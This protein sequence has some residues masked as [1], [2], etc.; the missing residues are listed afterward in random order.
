M[1]FN[2]RVGA[3]TAGK[4]TQRVCIEIWNQMKDEC[5]PVLN[6]EEWLNIAEGFKKNANFPHCIG[7]IDGKHIRLIRPNETGTMHF[8]YKKFFSIVLLAAVDANYRFIFVNI[9]SYG[10]CSDS[11]IFQ[12]CNLWQKVQDKSIDLPAPELLEG[13]TSNKLPYV[14]VADEAFAL[15]PNLLRPYGGDD[16]SSEKRI[17]NYRLTRARRYVECAFGILAN[18]WRIFHRPMNVHLDFA[19]DIVKACCV[20]H[21]HVRRREGIQSESMGNVRNQFE[22]ITQNSEE[23]LVYGG[24]YATQVR[25]SYCA[26]FNSANGQ[27][28]WQN[29]HA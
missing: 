29:A 17:F 11:N 27:V 5:F 16:L 28:P 9:G 14:F 19:C 10:K 12:E 6:K 1:H 24:N 21:N 20:L 8:N 23:E 25:D 3:S 4:F 2:Y 15:S 26:Y 18:K 22:D 7:A 13:E